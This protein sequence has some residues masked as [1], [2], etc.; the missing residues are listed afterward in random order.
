MDRPLS[1]PEGIPG[2]PRAH[3]EHRGASHAGGNTYSGPSA[4]RTWTFQLVS[5]CLLR[6]P[7]NRT[8]ILHPVARSLDLR[9]HGSRGATHMLLA[10]S[11][12]HVRLLCLTVSGWPRSRA[13]HI[14]SRGHSSG[15]FSLAVFSIDVTIPLNHRCMGILPTKSAKIVDPLYAHGFVLL[16]AEQPIVLCAVDW[17]EIRNGAYD[18]WRDALAKAAGTT[19][20]RVLVC[21]LHQHDAPVTDAGAAKLLA[22]VGLPGEL[23]D[24]AFHDDAVR[25]IA[26][27]LQDSL[28]SARRITHVGLGQARVESVASNRR[29]VYPDGRVTFRSRQ[30]QRSRGVLSRSTGRPD[31]SL[32]ED[33][34]VLG[35]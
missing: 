27:A 23:Y 10:Y 6:Q 31:R 33:D 25:R 9:E 30:S 26:T 22:D 24:E 28:P 16:G 3:C 2:R 32:A 29:V 7:T 11:R 1:W 21:S 5:L 12:A 15:E 17:C 4:Q 14:G 35:R 13:F 20:Q 34:F 8:S 18:Q 19:R